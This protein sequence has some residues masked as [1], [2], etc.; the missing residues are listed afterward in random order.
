MTTEQMRHLIE[1][2]RKIYIALYAI[3]M[4]HILFKLLVANNIIYLW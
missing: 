4:R 2:V 3:K 1:I